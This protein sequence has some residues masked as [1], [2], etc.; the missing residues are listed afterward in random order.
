MNLDKFS[1]KSFTGFEAKTINKAF[2]R[3]QRPFHYAFHSDIKF[4]KKDYKKATI[5]LMPHFVGIFLD[6]KTGLELYRKFHI[7]EIILIAVQTDEYV[8]IKTQGDKL[9]CYSKGMIKF[10]QLLYRNIYLSF[11][12]GNGKN[13]VELRSND[14]EIF[15]NINLKTS[16]SQCFQ[17]SYFAYCTAHEMK[18]DQEFVRYIHSLFLADCPIIDISMV[19]PKYYS[20]LY[21]L[22]YSRFFTGLCL[23]DYCCPD[24]LKFF[25][26]LIATNDRIRIIHFS[27]CKMKNG[28]KE[29]AKSS[30][31]VGNFA[32]NYWDLSG[33]KFDDFDYFA[34]VIENS[35]EPIYYLNVNN[36]SISPDTAEIF[37][38]ALSDFQYIRKLKF[39][40][41][42]GIGLDTNES[43]KAFKK[44]LKI[45]ELNYLD[46]GSLPDASHALHVLQNVNPSLKTLVLKNSLFDKNSASALI[47]F[48]KYTKT[49]RELDIS[50]TGMRLETICNIIRVISENSSLKSFSLHLDSL[51]LN[52]ESL[53]T[54]INSFQSGDYK[55]SKW[56]SLSFASN[57]LDM[58]D[59][60]CLLH[61]FKKLTRIQNINLDFNFDSSMVDIGQK[62]CD[63]IFLDSITSISLAGNTNH[64]LKNELIV[65]LEQLVENPNILT[66]LNISGNSLKSKGISLLKQFV[67]SS[68]DLISLNAENVGFSTH[69]KVKS[70]LNVVNDCQ[71]LIHFPFPIE[72]ASKIY[73]TSDEKDI[74]SIL[75]NLNAR[76]SQI[77]NRHRLNKNLTCQLPFEVPQDVENYLAD[78]ISQKS[79]K[80]SNKI[81]LHSMICEIFGLPLPFQQIGESPEDG[82]DV[83]E[84]N[85]GKLKVYCAK[86][87]SEYVKESNANYLPVFGP[88][89][90]EYIEGENV[91]KS[92]KR[93]SK[94]QSE[95]DGKG[96]KNRVMF[97]NDDTKQGKHNTSLNTVEATRLKTRNVD[98]YSL[99]KLVDTDLIDKSKLRKSG[100]VRQA[101][102][103]HSRTRTPSPKMS[104]KYDNPEYHEYN[105]TGIDPNEIVARNIEFDEDFDEPAQS[106]QKSQSYQKQQYQKSQSTKVL[107]KPIKSQKNYQYD[108]DIYDDNANKNR[109]NTNN[110][111]NNNNSS[112]KYDSDSDSDRPIKRKN[113]QNYFYENV[114]QNFNQNTSKS[115]SKNP[116]NKKI[117]SPP[118]PLLQIG[119]S[120][121]SSSDDDGEPVMKQLPVSSI[122]PIFSD[123]LK[124]VSPDNEP[125]RKKKSSNRFSSSRHHSVS[126][127]REI[128]SS[129]SSPFE[130][131]ENR[132]PLKK[133]KPKF[134]ADDIYKV[135]QLKRP[136]HLANAQAALDYAYDIMLAEEQSELENKKKA[137]I[138]KPDNMK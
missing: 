104:R 79:K 14:P 53:K 44:F 30:K 130:D 127:R 124:V 117:A 89:L 121:S 29:L 64:D 74:L 95:N 81:K 106:Y 8:L 27:N 67:K 55:L 128:S 120:S 82:G 62:L 69:E 93:H 138:P 6:R 2:F 110:L 111:P 18:Y 45:S 37:L 135:S 96:H 133:V 4:N 26:Q 98:P 90:N 21:S 56:K 70:F 41:I 23:K 36:C 105:P 123:S 116:P 60:S 100:F 33:N 3:S 118:L 50:G 137:K 78:L 108:D 16:P 9:V 11:S 86:S 97:D 119:S 92:S 75:D 113:H 28:I 63:L 24:A 87:I 39:L 131:E 73:F 125:L 129:S 112:N 136:P 38:S 15:P 32:V 71:N 42:S 5:A 103:L 20:S 122:Q 31:K 12:L 43:I 84:K 22:K 48:L 46:I 132:E 1:D 72:D 54:I 101:P 102:P 52:G 88:T 94:S 47:S 61:F 109:N 19:E 115:M 10:A 57:D 114:N 58:K 76:S 34:N 40:S 126:Y 107:A 99:D 77:I 83:I 49:L 17:L 51:K 66:H 25:S 65:F 59:L 7:S 85:Y 91:L 134:E 35:T 68:K 13:Y 80:S